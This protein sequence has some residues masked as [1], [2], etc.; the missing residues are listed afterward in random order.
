MPDK[1]SNVPS[2]R[3]YSVIG[4]ES[5]RI[6]SASNSPELFSIAIKPLIVCMARQ[7]VSIGK[8]KGSVLEFF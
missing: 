2:S 7:V 1:S 3:V 6:A 5:L 4:G 8:M